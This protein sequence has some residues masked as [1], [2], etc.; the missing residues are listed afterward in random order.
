[1]DASSCSLFI[2]LFTLILRIFVFQSVSPLTLAI[3]ERILLEIS[4]ISGHLQVMD[5]TL[6]NKVPNSAG[7]SCIIHP[8]RSQHVKT[9][10]LPCVGVLL[11]LSKY[12]LSTI[13]MICKS[14]LKDLK[15]LQLLK[16][17]GDHIF[18]Y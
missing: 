7:D 14:H 12:S 8:R 17:T 11:Q 9:A 6:V 16:N 1:M 10:N 5:R 3:K 18:T 15:L 4:F 2:S 13:L